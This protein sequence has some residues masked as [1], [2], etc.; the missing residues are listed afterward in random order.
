MA[1][2]RVRQKIGADAQHPYLKTVR[3]TGYMFQPS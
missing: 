3:G 2:S 1:I